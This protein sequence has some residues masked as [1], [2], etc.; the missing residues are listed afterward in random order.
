MSEN[1]DLY[2]VAEWPSITRPSETWYLV[3]SLHTKSRLDD[4]IPHRV[5]RWH[6]LPGLSRAEAKALAQRLQA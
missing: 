4:S 2:A 5:R 3:F 1:R 6:G